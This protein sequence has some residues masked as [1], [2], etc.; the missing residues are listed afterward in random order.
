MMR[1]W[2][3]RMAKMDGNWGLTLCGVLFLALQPQ[4]CRDEVASHTLNDNADVE[5]FLTDFADNMVAGR[6]A[7][8]SERSDALVLALDQATSDVSNTDLR[9][10]AQA[11]WFATTLQWQELEVMQVASL[12]SSL[13]AVGGADIRDNIYSWPLSNPCRLDQ[14]TVNG[15][16]TSSD[17]GETALVSMRGLDAIEYLLFAPLETECPSQV[18]PVSDGA[19]QPAAAD[20]AA[21][22]AYSSIAE[23]RELLAAGLSRSASRC[24][25]TAVAHCH[26]LAPQGR[27]TALRHQ[28]ASNPAHHRGQ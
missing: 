24:P 26:H 13:S 23:P 1:T 28:T 25:P 16:F 4:A 6:L 15:E 12:A 22:I 3:M 27:Q 10:A 20:Q 14:V 17:F 18:P 9:V 5:P 11:E 21:A 19:S 8:M 7:L 2:E